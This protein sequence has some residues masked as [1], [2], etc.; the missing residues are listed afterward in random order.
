[1]K[2]QLTFLSGINDNKAKSSDNKFQVY[3]NESDAYQALSLYTDAKKGR[4]VELTKVIY[5]DG[6][7]CTAKFITRK[8]VAETAIIEDKKTEKKTTKT[9]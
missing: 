7:P 5:Q 1:M 3:E 8:F 6:K 9:K 4:V 2:Y